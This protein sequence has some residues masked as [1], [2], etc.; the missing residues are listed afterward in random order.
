M[1]LPASEQL[2]L[3]QAGWEEVVRQHQTCLV[4]SFILPLDP[5]VAST[6]WPQELE[7]GLNE[8]GWVLKEKEYAVGEKEQLEAQ[9][10]LQ[11]FDPFVL[12][13]FSPSRCSERDSG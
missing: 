12:L 5:K 11:R 10:R 3:A 6:S 13:P 7:E 2:V 4:G 8:R 1:A 9:L